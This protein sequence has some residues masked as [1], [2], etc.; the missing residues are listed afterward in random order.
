MFPNFPKTEWLKSRED[1][2]YIYAP[3]CNTGSG[4]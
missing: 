4:I 3:D 1:I 2:S